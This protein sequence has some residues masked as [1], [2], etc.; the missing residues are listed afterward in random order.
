M[1]FRW[2]VIHQGRVELLPDRQMPRYSL[3]QYQPDTQEGHTQEGHTQ[4]GHT[5]EG[6]TQEGHTQEGYQ[7]KIAFDDFVTERLIGHR[8]DGLSKLQGLAQHLSERI[9]NR[10][11]MVT[12]G[13]KVCG[14]NRCSQRNSD[15]F[16]DQ[17]TYARDGEIYFLIEDITDL[18]YSNDRS[19]QIDEESAGQMVLL[20]S[21]LQTDITFTIESNK[22]NLGQIVQAWKLGSYSSDPNQSVENRWG[23][24]FK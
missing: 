2:P 10:I 4:E 18:I 24:N 19:L 23:L 14:H 7:D 17:S 20:W 9:N 22:V 6:H 21:Q 1:R 12:E 13:F 3:E 5:Q 11:K 15:D 8:L 16:Y